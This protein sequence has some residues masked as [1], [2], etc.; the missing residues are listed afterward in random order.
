MNIIILLIFVFFFSFWF[1]NWYYQELEKIIEHKNI[2]NNLKSNTNTWINLKNFLIHFL[3]L[4]EKNKILIDSLSQEE[5]IYLYML[6]YKWFDFVITDTSDKFSQF[7]SFYSNLKNFHLWIKQLLAVSY[8]Y[9]NYEVVKSKI[10]KN[11][12]K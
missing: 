4:F 10:S 8:K 5:I 2:L 3:N 11:R 6:K 1:S 9:W 7:I 12:K